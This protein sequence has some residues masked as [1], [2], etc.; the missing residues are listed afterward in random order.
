M[1]RPKRLAL[2]L[3]AWKA[4]LLNLLTIRTHMMIGLIIP[5]FQEAVDLKPTECSVYNTVSD[6]ITDQWSG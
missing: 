1:E 2:F 6:K 4:D 5:L 3:S